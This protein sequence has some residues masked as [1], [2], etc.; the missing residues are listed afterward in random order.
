MGEILIMFSLLR[1]VLLSSLVLTAL[2]NTHLSYAE[3][4]HYPD[5]QGHTVFTNT[6]AKAST[7]N[8]H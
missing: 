1:T 5:V 3:I 7:A 8:L 2:A 4:Y 6:P